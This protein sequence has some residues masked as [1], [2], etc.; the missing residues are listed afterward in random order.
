MT[1]HD[2]HHRIPHRTD[3]LIIGAGPFGLSLG[4]YC[5]DAGLDYM[6]V[7]KSMEL[8]RD[9]MP[10]GMN[11]RSAHDWHLDANNR[12]TFEAYLAE[13]GLEAKKTLPISRD[14]YLGYVNWFQNKKRLQPITQYVTQLEKSNE[15]FISKLDNGD[16]IQSRHVVIALGFQ[17]FAY[18]PQTL[19]E[20]IPTSSSSHTC[21]LVNFANLKDKRCLI[22]GGRQSAFE[23]AALIKDAGA[24][25]IH[26]SHRHD[27]PPPLEADW[28]WVPNVVGKMVEDE[29]W[30][31]NLSVDEKQHYN[32]QLWHEGRLKIEPWLAPHLAHPSIRTW[33]NTEVTQCQ[34]QEDGSLNIQLSNGQTLNI[35]HVIYATGYK[36]N[37]FKIPFLQNS[38]LVKSLKLIN[39]Q[40]VLDTRFQTNVD[41]L[42]I[43][44][45]GATMQFGSFFGFTV[46]VRTSAQLIGK[47][48]QATITPA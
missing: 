31:P 7:G 42:Y 34:Q 17:Y 20:M 35:D 11:L 3:T 39:N 16:V 8:W 48:L 1:L 4:A 32:Q 47:D 13:L 27:N 12:A 33:A 6:I 38:S 19:S 2:T 26:L 43:T 36:P 44:S 9:H 30:Y 15:L 28:S 46:S 5:E 23:W 40:P 10:Q 25:Q 37:V 24:S 29:T 18:I 41:G 14:F 22:I 21:Q 45:L